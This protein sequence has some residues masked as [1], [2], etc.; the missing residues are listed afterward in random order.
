MK[1]NIYCTLIVCLFFLLGCSSGDNK[2]GGGG[3]TA[4]ITIT[5]GT[6][7]TISENGGEVSISFT[8]SD[9]WNASVASVASS[10][11]EIGTKS[12]KA[13]SATI[14]ATIKPND[15]YSER[16]ASVTISSGKAKAS[17]TITQK[18]NDAILI[19]SDKV[20]LDVNGGIFEIKVKSN[21]NYTYTVTS[22]NEWIK[23]GD[24]G[25][26]ALKESSIFLKADENW[27]PE[28]RE[29]EVTVTNGSITEKVKI[30]Q[31]GSTK[32]IV[33]SQKIYNLTSNRTEIAVELKSNCDYEI[34]MPE[35]DWVKEVQ[36]KA[37]SSYTHYFEI[38]ENKTYD[39]RKATIKFVNKEENV[40]DSVE[41]N[42]SQ[43]NAIIL[44]ADK[45]EVDAKGDTLEFIVNTNVD[46]KIS[47]DVEW[48]KEITI[49]TKTLVEIPLAFTISKN[50]L[51]EVRT[52]H[53]KL[54][55]GDII[56]TVTVNQKASEDLTTVSFS[57]NGKKI[58][59]PEVNGSNVSG[60]IDWG[61]SKTQEY[62]K[63]ASHSYSDSD[64]KNVV[65]KVYN[66]TGVK[67]NS[68][69]SISSID[70]EY[71]ENE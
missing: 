1:K 54:T 48:I 28:S 64:N 58:S 16:N 4:T 30:Y 35:V 44:A 15:S 26:K 50:P 34:E 31:Q 69:K 11:C 2:G 61:D 29:G 38:S 41:I 22:G 7:A 57:H 62:S 6:S 47:T 40:S 10:W 25:T 20:E 12:G 45:Y 65:I 8:S 46:F 9:T 27:D 52:G 60:T 59:A 36:T 49:G 68:L 33:V 13:G 63:S 71:S 51:G 43:V 3:G 19:S 21:V 14:I 37:V 23:E 67:F 70:F 24:L 42:Q 18:Q 39:N 55:A 32:R 53:I 66:A 56:Q 17:V 5:S